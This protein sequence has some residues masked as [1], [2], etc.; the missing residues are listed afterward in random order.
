MENVKLEE[1]F[2]QV[3]IWPGTIVPEGEEQDFVD[4]IKSQFDCRAQY[5]E[6][7][8]T[9]PD[10]GDTSGETGGRNDIFF[11]IHK[12]D[13]KKF[14]I[15]RMSFGM[16]WIEDATS[17]INGYPENPIYPERILQYKSW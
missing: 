5:L 10:D 8:K 7:I 1:G 17:E 14:A 3:V 2:E 16:R 4:W 9:K 13:V 12:E 11:T 15:P 6:Q